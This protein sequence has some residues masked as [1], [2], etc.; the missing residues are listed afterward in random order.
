[1]ARQKLRFDF[2][3]SCLSL[4]QFGLVAVA[5]S[6]P[7][8]QVIPLPPRVLVPALFVLGVMSAW[9]LGFILDHMDFLRLY[10]DEQNRRN[11]VLQSI[12]NENRRAIR[13]EF[14]EQTKDRR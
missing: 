7:L 9:G 10:Q 13:N 14:Y 5:A 6:G 12:A 11:A 1:M 8:M 2:G 3:Y 4:I